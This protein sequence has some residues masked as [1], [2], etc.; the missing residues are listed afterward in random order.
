MEQLYQLLRLIPNV[1]DCAISF[2]KFKEYKDSSG[3]PIIGH[4]FSKLKTLFLD[5]GYGE[6]F[7]HAFQDA[8]NL[9]TLTLYHSYSILC[10]KP[11]LRSLRIGSNDT[12][13]FDVILDNED[14]KLVD[15]QIDNLDLKPGTAF[16]NFKS[17]IET[18]KEIENFYFSYCD[19]PLDDFNLILTHIL[20]LETLRSVETGISN[21]FKYLPSDRIR[22]YQVRKLIIDRGMYFEPAVLTHYLKIFPGITSLRTHPYSL[23]DENIL[24]INN[25][26]NLEELSIVS[27]IDGRVS[28]EALEEIQI[29]SLKKFFWSGYPMEY[30]NAGNFEK[31]TKNNPN[32]VDL[33]LDIGTWIG[34]ESLEVIVKNLKSLKRLTL[35]SLHHSTFQLEDRIFEI[36][37]EHG[38]NLEYLEMDL[39]G[40]ENVMSFIERAIVHFTVF[41]P[42]LKFKFYH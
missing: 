35:S 30:F 38:E 33:T 11:K 29:P 5:S 14:L 40:K 20:N 17:F 34:I 4:K 36:L 25:L 15:L 2:L 8:K 27:L 21:V 28:K 12:I 39:Q 13:D 10:N 31:F 3:F 9:E 7:A 26:A 18:Q 42:N 41:L 22:N 1:E 32:I 23:L 37:I 16:E 19:G 6:I 24:L